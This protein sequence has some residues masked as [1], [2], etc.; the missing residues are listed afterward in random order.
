MIYC[1]ATLFLAVTISYI[2]FTRSA[3]GLL[4]GVKFP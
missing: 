3:L 1:R 2:H 4:K